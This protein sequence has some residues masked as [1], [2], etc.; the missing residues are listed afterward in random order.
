VKLCVF[1]DTRQEWI[2]YLFL[3]PHEPYL[4]TRLSLEEGLLDYQCP[5]KELLK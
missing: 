1:Y 2:A 3:R 5:K 4:S